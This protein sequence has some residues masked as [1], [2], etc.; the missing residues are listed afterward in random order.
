MVRTQARLAPRLPIIV[1]PISQPDGSS[2]DH[3][4]IIEPDY[5]GFGLSD[6]PSPDA[7]GCRF[8]RTSEVIEKALTRL[9]FGRFGLYVQDNGEP[10]GFALSRC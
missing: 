7:Y 8:H 10:V 4:H 1:S 9:G 5:P 6:M 2:S 3:F